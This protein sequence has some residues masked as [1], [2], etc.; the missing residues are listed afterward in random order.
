ML[1]LTLEWQVFEG[2]SLYSPKALDIKQDDLM[3]AVTAAIANVA[4]ISLQLGYPTLASIP[5][6]IVNGYKNVLAVS[7]A[8]EYTF[9]LAQKVC[10]FAAHLCS[11][12]LHLHAHIT[13]MHQIISGSCPHVASSFKLGWPCACFKYCAVDDWSVGANTSKLISK[14][15][16]D[17][18]RGFELQLRTLQVK[19]YLADPSAFAASDAPAA[20]GDSAAAAAPAAEAKKEESEEEQESDED[21]GELLPELPLV[22]TYKCV[23]ACQAALYIHCINSEQRQ[24][25]LSA[26]SL[27]S[28]ALPAS[29]LGMFMPCRP[30]STMRPSALCA[31]VGFQPKSCSVVICVVVIAGMGGMF[32]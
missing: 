12:G 27:V 18:K 14:T 23:S 6:S 25:C 15:N 31:R 19:D 3:S 22:C 21:M 2:G 4:A 17:L 30:L 9:D 11:F 7:V 29:W 28:H 13:C 32:D 26:P 8:T 24:S 16:Q 20:A 10:T 1:T 5:H